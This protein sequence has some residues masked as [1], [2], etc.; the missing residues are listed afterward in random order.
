[1][2]KSVLCWAH[3]QCPPPSFLAPAVTRWLMAGVGAAV[4]GPGGS[5]WGGSGVEDVC[6]LKWEAW[7]PQVCVRRVWEA[8]KA[9]D[10]WGGPLVTRPGVGVCLYCAHRGWRGHSLEWV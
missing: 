6:A 9:A 4:G 7:G 5:V 10:L 8:G 1:M 2:A 3:A